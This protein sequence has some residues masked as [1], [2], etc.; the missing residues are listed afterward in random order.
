MPRFLHPTLIAGT[1]NTTVQSH[2]SVSHPDA[3]DTLSVDETDDFN[4]P[5]K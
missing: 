2:P 3:E 5:Q 1:S 4:L